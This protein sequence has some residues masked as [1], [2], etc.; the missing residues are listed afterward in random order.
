[1][2]A[3]LTV[4]DT[5][6]VILH[7]FVKN[8]EYP[9]N[10][11]FS[12]ICKKREAYMGVI[13]KLIENGTFESTII[14]GKSI[15]RINEMLKKEGFETAC[16]GCFVESRRLQIQTWAKTF[17]DEWNDAVRKV[18]PNATP[19][20]FSKGDRGKTLLTETEISNIESE[21]S[22][23]KKNKTGGQNLGQG[24]V[25][26]KMERLLQRSPS[27][28]HTIGTADLLT[29][30][31]LASLRG[32]KDI[33]SL[34]LG[35]YGSNTPKP[36]QDFNP[37]NGEFAE[38]TGKY[39][40][41]IFGDGIKGLDGYRKS[42][43]KE[44][45]FTEKKPSKKASDEQ[46]KA[47]NEAKKQYEYDVET[48]AIRE[49]LFD[50]GGAR[51]QSFSDF[52]IENTLDYFQMVADLSVREFPMHAYTKEIV[53]ARI[54]GMTG[55]KINMSLIADVDTS[56]GDNFIGL[57]KTKN[58]YDFQWGD[59]ERNKATNNESYIQSIGFKDALAL[60]LDKRYSANTGTI[61]VGVSIGHIVKCLESS[62]IRMC[63]PYHSSGMNAIFAK[64]MNIDRYT[65]FT[66][67][68]NTTIEGFYD[69]NGKR[70][71]YN[72]GGDIQV[73]KAVV[74]SFGDFE[75]NKALRTMNPEEAVK[76]Y[77][78]WCNEM[79]P[80]NT[81]GVFYKCTP[82]FDIE[83]P[84]DVKEA[85]GINYG[86][87]TESPNYYKLIE[88]FNLYDTV[89]GEYAR[90]TSLDTTYAEEGLSGDELE[91][92]KRRLR[93]SGY[94]T[95]KEIEKYAETASKNYMEVIRDEISD[96]AKYH[97][98][99]D[100]KMDKTIEDISSELKV[101][102]S[103]QAEKAD[104]KIVGDKIVSDA[105]YDAY[106][107][108]TKGNK[109]PIEE[110]LM[111]PEIVEAYQRLPK[112][113]SIDINTPER[114][115]MRKQKAQE[116]LERGSWV[117][118]SDIVDEFSKGKYSGSVRRESKV[119]LVIGLPASGKSSAAVNPISK[120]FGAR[121]LDS[122][123]IKGMLPEYDN[124]YG[125]GYVHEESK[126][127]LRE[128]E[129]EALLRG[130]NI[131]IPIVGGE[132][133]GLKN[134]INAFNEIG[135]EVSLSICELSSPK[136]I[137]RALYRFAK[138]DRF[139]PIE[140]LYGYQNKP[141]ENYYALLGDENEKHKISSY[142]ELS[143]DV[144]IGERPVFVSGKGTLKN[145]FGSRSESGSR[146]AENAE[147]SLESETNNEVKSS[148]NATLFSKQVERPYDDVTG[149][150][151]SLERANE[152]LTDDVARLRKLLRL[153]GKVTK[154]K[155]LNDHQLEVAA[156]AILK[157]AKSKYE[158]EAMVG[159][160]QEIYG[161]ILDNYDRDESKFNMD[162]IM[163]KCMDAASRVMNES[164]KAKVEQRYPK[165]VLAKIA[166]MSIK[167]G[168][169][170]ELELKL[171]YGDGWKT[172]VKKHIKI[173]DKGSCGHLPQTPF[174]CN[175]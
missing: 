120:Y 84:T 69:S 13:S 131:V 66:N 170:S 161:Y 21:L 57:T 81:D 153:Q 41:S 35:R 166:S 136:A 110:L 56:V 43:K 28:A 90:Q 173:S 9:V 44:H 154:G 73:G 169:R 105:F 71:E 78:N 83:I 24:A 103:S 26:E 23:G 48:N 14:D 107:K 64:L 74:K 33:Y 92:Y 50:I 55:M 25:S 159:E 75:F 94:F 76:A 27:L 118:D 158:T 19:F 31:G 59:K 157:G 175:H 117:S 155:V 147:R 104:S 80:T 54:F 143:T 63:I 17:C 144:K 139:I 22:K 167:V 98:V 171:R 150:R 53:F 2:N 68:Q 148:V 58:G 128:V 142:A 141:T 100:A 4:S 7:S 36:V 102:K 46:K 1:M 122:D 51:V 10:I 45:P 61:A 37:Y 145:V 93:D 121:V 160:L 174:P 172:E 134:R 60:I 15:A 119:T 16:L 127:I 149:S 125:S 49:Y 132:L 113:S 109:M 115:A 129:R 42:Y 111:I 140:V 165:E 130:E 34:L 38:L 162:I 11:D 39:I 137:G 101:M 70:I 32:Y 52:L 6:K 95:E 123:D 87:L 99:Q 8:G 67:Y 112:G 108:L 5:G 152:K 77:L 126:L 91:E 29:P 88:D 40:T 156:R 72:G 133:E 85:F 168:K 65:D 114:K 79:H 151:K 164:G 135:Y 47:Y 116:Y 124:G 96:R 86:R 97:K 18:N 163:S 3:E 30:D 62:Y 146:G 82:K 12:T 106:D 20:G 89:T 138:D